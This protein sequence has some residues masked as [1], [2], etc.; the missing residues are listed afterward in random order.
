M[1]WVFLKVLGLFWGFF[2]Q[3]TR[4]LVIYE[5]ILKEEGPR[6]FYGELR[7]YGIVTITPR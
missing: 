7:R 3:K 4:F 6:W 5:V 1:S 2:T